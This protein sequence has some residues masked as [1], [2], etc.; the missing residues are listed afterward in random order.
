MRKFKR[1]L[2][3][4]PKDYVKKIEADLWG[5]SLFGSVFYGLSGW[6]LAMP[7]SLITFGQMTVVFF[8]LMVGRGLLWRKSMQISL[9]IFGRGSV[10]SKGSMEGLLSGNWR[11]IVLRAVAAAVC[12]A[13]ALEGAEQK[14]K[15]D[16]VCQ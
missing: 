14:G 10:A 2:Q 16:S 12:Y 5:N 3:Y 4:R 1:F 11:G 7:V 6:R 13:G 8:M 9:F 15:I